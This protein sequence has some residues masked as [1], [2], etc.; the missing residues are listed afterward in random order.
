MQGPSRR[1]VLGLHLFPAIAVPDAGDDAASGV[2][3]T[4]ARC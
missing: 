3:R 2:R 4:D 1:F